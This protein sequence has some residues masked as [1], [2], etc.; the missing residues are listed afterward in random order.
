MVIVKEW[1]SGGDKVTVRTE[2]K[3]DSNGDWT[4][5]AAQWK[6]RHEADVAA[7]LEQFP[8]DEE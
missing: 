8:D 1:R 7:A 3:K 2:R 4:E 6:S 5:T